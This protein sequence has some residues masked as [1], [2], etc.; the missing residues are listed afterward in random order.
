MVREIEYL[1]NVLSKPI[2]NKIV[3]ED[4][5]IPLMH[6]WFVSGFTDAEGCFNVK[7][8]KTEGKLA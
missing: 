7:L 5:N 6:P 8:T 1:V 4:K 3:F 2:S